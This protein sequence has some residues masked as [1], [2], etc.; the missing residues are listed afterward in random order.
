[1][2]K[3]SQ[4]LFLAAWLAYILLMLYGTFFPFHFQFTLEHLRG[5]SHGINWFPLTL[6]GDIAM[7][8]I[9]W[10][11][12]WINMLLFIPF[13]FLAYKSFPGRPSRRRF[14]SL[15]TLGFLFSLSIE[16]T[17]LFTETRDT[18]LTD[19]I[20]NTLSTVTGVLCAIGMDVLIRGS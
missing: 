15:V 12:Y 2:L 6:F 7:K 3:L 10:A 16:S 9:D 5:R 4:T 20:W 19:V 13:G 11:D 14:A 18:S 1:M 17:Q 8:P